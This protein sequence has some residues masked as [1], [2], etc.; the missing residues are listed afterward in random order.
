MSS[1]VLDYP[2]VYGILNT[3]GPTGAT[4]PAGQQGI[5]G[6]TGPPGESGSGSSGVAFDVAHQSI[7]VNNTSASNSGNYNNAFGYDTLTATTSGI[8]NNA[9]GYQALKN[10]NAYYNSAFG[11]QALYSNTDS[12]NC[13]FGAVSLYNNTTGNSNVAIG[14]LT[15]YQNENGINNTA[16]G[17]YAGFY[18]GTSKTN[19][20]CLGF[21]AT[22]T[23]NNQVILG[24][25]NADTYVKGGSVQS[26]SDV[27]DK[28]EV[29]N[30]V[31]G[32]N[33]IERLRPVDYK[34]DHRSSYTGVLL[35]TTHDC[36]GNPVLKP[37][38]I[39][40]LKDG[41]KKG[42]RFHHGLI[43]QEVKQVMD[44]MNV[45]FGGYQDHKVNGGEDQITIGYSE[46]IAPLI[47]A[48]QELSKQNKE[49]MRQI[50]YLD[51]ENNMLPDRIFLL[52]NRK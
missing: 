46:L 47:K 18:N 5:Q 49:I 3:P 4:G 1:I 10:T 22:A 27:R 44:E 51:S 43:A 8:G 23:G 28:A 26:I 31:L 41:S 30:T 16:V 15:L 45:D 34:W 50:Q 2:T 14:S 40:K 24:D 6:P 32:L 13:A 17:M 20:T 42:K 52:E 19:T 12:H 35:K 25:G 29:K 33:F 21:Q 9:F 48:V 37:I 7:A 39:K 36:S 11:N 38:E